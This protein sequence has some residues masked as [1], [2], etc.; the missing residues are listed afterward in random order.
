[1]LACRRIFF[2]FCQ[3]CLLFCLDKIRGSNSNPVKR[4][5]CLNANSQRCDAGGTEVKTEERRQRWV[6]GDKARE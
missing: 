3:G 2:F 1:M 6:W 5:R 4:G